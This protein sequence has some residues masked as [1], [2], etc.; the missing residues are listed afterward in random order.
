MRMNKEVTHEFLHELLV[1]LNNNGKFLISVLTDQTGLPI[2]S[3][4]NNDESEMQAAVVAQVRRIS[5]QVKLQLGMAETDEINLNDINGR[6]LVSRSFTVKDNDF[7]LA[8]LFCGRDTPYRR[9]TTQTIL[10]IKASLAR[11]N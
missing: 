6:R 2:A 11:D 4:A 5:N 9:L 3:S 7:M 1:D 8:I 10:A